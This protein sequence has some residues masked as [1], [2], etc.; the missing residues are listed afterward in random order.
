MDILDVYP[1]VALPPG[2]RDYLIKYELEG[3]RLLRRITNDPSCTKH[4][5]RYKMKWLEGELLT[6]PG[7]NVS[8]LMV[9]AAVRMEEWIRRETKGKYNAAVQP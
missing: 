5:E 3:W 1:G 4:V 2:K 8:R 9:E 6:D 7:Y